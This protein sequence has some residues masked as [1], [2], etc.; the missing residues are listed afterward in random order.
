[1]LADSDFTT[2][3]VGLQVVI[4]IGNEAAKS[5]L[6]Q[7][8]YQRRQRL[9]TRANREDVI[10]QEVL[11]AVDQVEANWQRILA[12]RQTSILNGRLYE[13]EQR[14]F[15]Q[16]LRTSTDVLDA[17]IRFANAQS[18]EIVALADYQ[19]SLVDV[20]YATGTLL[21]SPRSAGSRSS[22]KP[23]SS[24]SRPLR[25]GNPSPPRSVRGHLTSRCS[26]ADKEDRPVLGRA[27]AMF[28]LSVHILQEECRHER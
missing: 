2:H 25:S 24:D 15:E 16:G 3:S 26:F 14:Q 11:N 5:R 9:A 12:A 27:D 23:T 18:N 6:R 19:I 13:A 4:P 28:D 1:M 17:Q 22:P 20:A 8:I 7:Y 10:R 21:G